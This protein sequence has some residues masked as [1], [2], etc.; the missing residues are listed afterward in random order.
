MHKFSR[1]VILGA[2]LAVPWAAET[3][4]GPSTDPRPPVYPGPD[5][6]L[7]Y[8]YV[9]QIEQLNGY[10][11][12]IY[13]NGVKLVQL[14]NRQYTWIYMKSGVLNLEVRMPYFLEKEQ[15]KFSPFVKGGEIS[16]L[17]FRTE[18]GEKYIYG[19]FEAVPKLEAMRD[20]RSAMYEKLVQGWPTGPE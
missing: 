17:R 18:L 7:V 14:T 8:F 11:F 19:L 9:P 15:V 16:Y 3:V 2:T 12:D 6:A 5:Q 1:R 4:A 20:M 13:L 10:F